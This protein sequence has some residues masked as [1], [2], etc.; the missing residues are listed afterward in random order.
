MY[1]TE[2]QIQVSYCYTISNIIQCQTISYKVIRKHVQQGNFY[3]QRL[4]GYYCTEPAMQINPEAICSFVDYSSDNAS[5]S[6]DQI[7]KD[8]RAQPVLQET[9]HRGTDTQKLEIQRRE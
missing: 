3:L 7:Q 5:Q 2:C 4:E 9:Q 6:E 8:K 1:N